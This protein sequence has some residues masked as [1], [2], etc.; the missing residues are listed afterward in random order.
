MNMQTF[1]G[2]FKSK[3]LPEN[4]N[5]VVIYSSADGK[6]GEVPENISFP[7]TSMKQMAKTK[8]HKKL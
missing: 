6:S 3:G 4:E 7:S 8:Q 2:V 5:S 1:V